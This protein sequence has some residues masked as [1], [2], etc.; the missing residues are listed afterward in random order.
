MAREN[1]NRPAGD[2]AA[3]E[4]AGLASQ[5]GY[6][7]RQSLLLERI[8]A[9][10]SCNLPS[11]DCYAGR[12]RTHCVADADH[13]A[14]L[15]QRDGRVF[16]E[17]A[18][19]CSRRRQEQAIEALVRAG[20][21]PPGVLH[22][23][24]PK[25]F[26]KPQLQTGE[27]MARER[28]ELQP[29][30]R[31]VGSQLEVCAAE[32][33]A[34]PAPDIEWLP[35]LGSLGYIPKGWSVLVAGYPKA[36]KTEFVTRLCASWVHERIL[37][38]TE[39]A[40]AIWAARLHRVAGDWR[41]MR[42]LFGLGLDPTHILGRIARGTETVVVVDTV[43][44]LL[45]LQDE[46]DNAEV[47]RAL[48]PLVAA[49]RAGK[50]TLV[51]LHHVR[52]GGG[53]HG[54]GVTGGHA[55]LGV[56]DVA[57]ELLRGPNL[58][59][60]RR[61]LRGWA[62]LFPI[63]EVVYELAPDG[64]MTLLGSRKEVELRSVEERVLALLDKEWRSTRELLDSLSEPRPSLEQLRQALNALVAKGLAR[65]DPTEERRGATYRWRRPSRAPTIPSAGARSDAEVEE[66]QLGVREKAGK[67]PADLTSNA[68]FY[69]LEVRL[70]QALA[71]NTSLEPRAH[72]VVD[73]PPED[74][75][76]VCTVCGVE[77]EGFSPEGIPRCGTHATGVYCRRCARPIPRG[78]TTCASCSTSRAVLA[79][80]R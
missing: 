27:G 53:E 71:A 58:G 78:T 11:C 41:H 60:T 69:R 34:R 15:L 79:E 31:L 8:A 59:D 43:R 20:R 65:R 22:V 12:G 28:A 4:D 49:A 39:E 46:S 9:V 10:L 55:F 75:A 6:S 77:A 70:Q 54:E 47:A 1:R 68:P 24:E 37:Y 13:P 18:A 67:S 52:K 61:R 19:R 56:V 40:E 30:E 16:I 73:L 3:G 72:D 33:A 51:L 36:G 5:G 35:L 63:E 2:R 42:L 44:N 62:R 80:E 29:I 38:V 17:C 57:L 66:I 50:K 32:L 7:T 64:S 45:R 76:F 25:A 74:E 14:R 26:S 23:V 21:F 48:I